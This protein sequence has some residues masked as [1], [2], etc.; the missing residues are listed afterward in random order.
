MNFAEQSFNHRSDGPTKRPP[1]G[2]PN[3]HSV[4][5]RYDDGDRFRVTSNAVEANARG[6]AVNKS[7]DVE[8][9]FREEELAGDFLEQ[10]IEALMNCGRH[11]A[12]YRRRTKDELKAQVPRDMLLDMIG[13]AR[14]RL[15]FARTSIL[16]AT[17]SAEAVVNEF[18]FAEGKKQ[19]LAAPDLESI[20]KMSTP[21]KYVLGVKLVTGE[22]I[23]HR[24]SGPGQT[25]TA[26][27]K[28]RRHLVHPRRRK[29]K[30]KK[31]NLFSQAGY[32]DFNP[33][34]AARFIVAVAEAAVVLEKWSG[35]D[36]SEYSYAAALSGA[37]DAILS[38]GKT[39]HADLPSRNGVRSGALAK[40]IRRGRLASALAPKTESSE[41][42]T[43]D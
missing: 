26:M 16:F 42:S 36:E 5:S 7:K 10:S 33:D 21:D 17:L 8:W 22:S 24:G 41:D 18:I 11:R 43:S 35:R 3:G 23:F 39:A 14:K 9:E 29:V 13:A 37:K 25:I 6:S 40:Q 4:Q 2:T 28:L 20:D 1:G 30:V 32:E 27:F 38:L 34:A 15:E 12:L 31:G 19:G